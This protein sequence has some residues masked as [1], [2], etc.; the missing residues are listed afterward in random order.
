[1]REL[2]EWIDAVTPAQG[3]RP[4]VS[5][6]VVIAWAGLRQRAWFHHGAAL[7]SAPEPGTLV[8][9]MELRTQ[10]MPTTSE[11]SQAGEAAAALF[12]IRVSPH[13]TAP[14]VADL[15]AT[16][17]AKATELAPAAAALVP[18]IETAYRR[19]ALDPNGDS[20]PARHRA[21]DLGAGPAAAPAARGRARAGAGGSAPRRRR[22]SGRALAR[23]GPG[24]HDGVDRRSSGSG[25]TRSPPP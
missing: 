6:L 4:E 8:P 5:D 25:W 21:D 7:P 3:L 20:A 2:R 1:M 13:L 9:A 11:W 22:D 12:G 10:P 14:A 15:V 16:V 23:L 19:M 17:T 18:A 24:G